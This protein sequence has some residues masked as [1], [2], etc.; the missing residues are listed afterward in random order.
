MN[1][2]VQ[3]LPP[4]G[5][6]RIAQII[7][8]KKNI[9]PIPPLIPVSRSTWLAGVKS[10]RYPQPIRG[11]GERVTVWRVEDIVE[12]INKLSGENCDAQKDATNV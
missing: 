12:L 2:K 7:G 1:S 4:T 10:N 3:Q 5:F 8:N 11:L 9:P 6:L